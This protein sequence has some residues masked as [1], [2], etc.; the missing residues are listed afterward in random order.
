MNQLN[1]NLLLA[2][3]YEDNCNFFKLKKVIE[4]EITLAS[5]NNYAQATRNNFILQS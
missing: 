4:E 5:E 1:Y 2:D 3:H